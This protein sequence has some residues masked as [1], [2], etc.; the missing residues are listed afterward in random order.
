LEKGSGQ[1]KSS[2]KT[3]SK[4]KKRGK[5]REMPGDDPPTFISKTQKTR[6]KKEKREHIRAVKKTRKI[7]KSSQ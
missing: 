2:K 1:T 7:G 6:M 5:Y 3:S 4:S